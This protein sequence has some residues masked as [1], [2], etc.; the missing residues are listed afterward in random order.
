M[1]AAVVEAIAGGGAWLLTVSAHAALWA[2]AA[3]LVAAVLRHRALAWQEVL[4]RLSLVAGLATGT[5]QWRAGGPA[6]DWTALSW[7]AARSPLDVAA[8]ADPWGA[9]LGGIA[10]VAEPR[11]LERVAP[12]GSRVPAPARADGAAAGGWPLRDGGSADAGGAAAAPDTGRDPGV[13]AASDPS[14]APFGLTLLVGSAMGMAVLGLW[15]LLVARRRLQC[16]LA[17]RRPEAD[18]RV[19]ALAAG[20]ARELGLP[21]TPRL[22]RCARLPSPIAFAL[23]R[24]EVCLPER[25]DELGDD[26]LRALFGHELAHVQRADAAWLLLGALVHALFPWQLWWIPVRRRLQAIAELRCDEAAASRA[27][28][29]AVASCLVQVASWLGSQRPPRGVLAMAARPSLLRSRVERALAGT[30]SR[31]LSRGSAT[32][33][34]AV[35]LGLFTAAA[36][37][38]RAPGVGEP[39]VRAAGGPELGGHAPGH[40]PSGAATGGVDTGDPASGDPM[41]GD[42][43]SGGPASGHPV[44]GDPASG[45]PASASAPHGL[46]LPIEPA[47]RAARSDR[48]PAPT[49][50]ADAPAAAPTPGPTAAPPTDG[51]AFELPAPTLSGGSAAPSTRFAAPTDAVDFVAAVQF[52][53]LRRQRSTLAQERRALAAEA[54]ELRALRDA[55]AE[56][57]ELRRLLDLLEVRLAALERAGERL[58]A[59]FARAESIRAEAP[60]RR[61]R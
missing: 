53:A 8:A 45:D 51:W 56:D 37:G 41:F 15:S 48:E 31:R 32:T 9:Q 26:E 28:G 23:V 39:G 38:V 4:L 49:A 44:F 7:P 60:A 47:L 14:A 5:A 36:P 11:S 55:A 34:I 33:V 13:A 19:L 43:A 20:V 21:H 52:A 40:A 6:T 46:R 29:V 25:I 17:E 18:A 50:P 22:S 3:L 30:G 54:R 2:G 58:E 59:A 10:D 35:S 61:M 42:P 12:L 24:P 1:S 27:G 57:M 16:L